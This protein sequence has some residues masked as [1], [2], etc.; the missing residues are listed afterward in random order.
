M[1]QE[2]LETLPISRMDF[3][4]LEIFKNVSFESIAGYLLSCKTLNINEGDIIIAP[5]NA[6]RRLI[7]LLS[8]LL[9]VKLDTNDNVF[10]NDITPGD[11]AGEMSIFDNVKPSATVFARQPSKILVIP[12]DIALAMINASHDLCL[13]FLHML[14]Q[15]IRHS[16]KVVCED[17]FHIR[18]IEEESK[19]DALTGLHNRR[20]LEDMY[21][22][23]MNRSNAGKFNL[24]AFMVDIDHFKH[25]NDN[26]GHLAGDQILKAVAQELSFS[27][28]P[29]DMPVRYGGE[30]FT[31][32]LPGT[33][34]ENALMIAERIRAN[35]EKM[36]IALASNQML[37]VTVSIGIT[38]RTAGDTVQSIIDRAD[39]AL[40]TAKNSGRNKA[41][42]V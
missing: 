26:Y 22:R 28:R 17:Q 29:S 37:Q 15:R 8:G 3:L 4:S 23:E 33:T 7:I 27:L 42:F 30:E 2:D 12:P 41:V 18:C 9:G 21:T 10:S 20:W 5:D 31:V 40:Y 25:V 39:G 35:I 36:K 14:S 6:E 11:C 32:F 19:V 1:E 16:N 38:M 24:C 13:N 34:K